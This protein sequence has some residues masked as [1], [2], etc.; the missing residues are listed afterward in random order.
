MLGSVWGASDIAIANQGRRR[1]AS[2]GVAAQRP[3]S[4]YHCASQTGLHMQY[5]TPNRRGAAPFWA[6][7]AVAALVPC[8]ASTAFGAQ[9]PPK[10]TPATPRNNPSPAGKTSTAAAVTPS[11]QKAALPFDE[12][13][14]PGGV[15]NLMFSD[16]AIRYCLAQIIRIDA[17]RPLVDRYERGQVDY[18][19]GLVA[20]YNNRC[21]HYRYVEGARES[22]QAQVEPS[23][24]KI[25]SD[26]REAYRKR[27]AAADKDASAKSRAAPTATP[28]AKATQPARS[29]ATVAA[30]TPPQAARAAT[31]ARPELKQQSPLGA[32]PLPS[33]PLPQAARPA[34]TPEPEA[35]LQGASATAPLPQPLPA[36]T[37]GAAATTGEP[38][39]KQQPQSPKAPTPAMAAAAQADRPEVGAAQPDL[40][41]QPQPAS[42]P[43][44]P[45]TQPERS[46]VAIAQPGAK[47]QPAAPAPVT[48]PPQGERPAAT[49]TQPEAKQQSQAASVP[50]A[51]VTQPE[52]SAVAIAQSEAKSQPAAPA[53]VTLPPQGERP[54]ATATQP[55]A[56]QQ[57]QAASVPAAPA[58]QPERSAVVAKAPSDAKSEPAGLAPAAPPPQGDRSAATAAPPEAKQPR[59]SA[60]SGPGSHSS[61][62]E[63]AAATPPPP[64][65]KQQPEP[66]PSLVHP[67]KQ[68]EDSPATPPPPALPPV[69]AKAQRD[70][71]HSTAVERFAAEVQRVASQVLDQRDYPKDARGKDWQG[72]TQIEVRYDAGGYI[73]SIVV[74]ESSGYPPLDDTA[75]QI[76]RNMR[77]PSAPDELRSREFAVR[78]PIVFRLRNP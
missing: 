8:A 31:T 41:Q 12:E 14:P 73:R 59:S 27:F 57:S 35:K 77:L 56:K 44:A 72:T 6:I 62:S 2:A 51:P 39:A 18:F 7:V 67:A 60:T 69:L 45:A 23:R 50:A 71:A 21:G 76:A 22:A 65:A 24:Q 55:E 63:R 40:K 34:T 19:N 49:A 42:V 17:V 1:V 58:T 5:A 11:T 30:P 4:S 61:Q 20:D 25:E 28:P 68:G 13:I 78:F 33:T 66:S 10:P 75:L 32:T 15:D 26:A 70:N 48:L 46:A 9:E 64:K 53:P 36:Q 74:G 16:A 43:A 38:A 29:P 47:S 3:S 37:E 52:R 54:A